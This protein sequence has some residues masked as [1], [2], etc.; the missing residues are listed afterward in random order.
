MGKVL[1]GYHPQLKMKED[2]FDFPDTEEL[3]KLHVNIVRAGFKWIKEIF[4]TEFVGFT[5]VWTLIPP[6][7]W[8][9]YAVMP[10]MG[11]MP[12]SILLRK[13]VFALRTKLVGRDRPDFFKKGKLNA[14][15]KKANK[16]AKQSK[17]TK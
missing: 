2:T 6:E 3:L 9:R 5:D 15:I 16:P 11:D 1:K 4:E 13:A 14:A 17:K 8:A 12:E 10:D 7:Q